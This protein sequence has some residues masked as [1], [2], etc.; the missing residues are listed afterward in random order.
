MEFFAYLILISFCSS[1]SPSITFGVYFLGI[2]PES[3]E[4][5]SSY[6]LIRFSVLKYDQYPYFLSFKLLFHDFR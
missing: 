2:I 4:H 3:F 5:H 1:G 6:F